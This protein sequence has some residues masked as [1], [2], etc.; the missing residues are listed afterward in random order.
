ML[1]PPRLTGKESAAVETARPE[2]LELLMIR[3]SGSRKAEAYLRSRLPP[4][5]PRATPIISDAALSPVE[6]IS[7]LTAYAIPCRHDYPRKHRRAST[8]VAA[9]RPRKVPASMTHQFHPA[10]ELGFDKY[11]FDRQYNHR[12]DAVEQHDPRQHPSHVG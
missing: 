4:Q 8:P 9:H 1:L 6:P 3:I 10:E 2:V 11:H 12:Q 7:V 5:A